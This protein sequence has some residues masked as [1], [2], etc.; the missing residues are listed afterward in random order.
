MS[1]NKINAEYVDMNSSYLY[2]KMI[3]KK[4]KQIKSLQNKINNLLLNKNSLISQ[5]DKPIQ[6]IP[7]LKTISPKNIYSKN[8]IFSSIYQDTISQNQLNLS[9]IKGDKYKN[10]FQYRLLSA[11]KEIEN[12]TIMNTSKDNIILNMQ[13]FIN[14]LNN[15][16]CNGKLNLNLNQIDIRLFIINLKFLEQKILKILQKIKAPNKIPDSIIESIRENSKKKPKIGN[17]KKGLYIIPLFSRINKLNTQS[18][19]N[20]NSKHSNNTNNSLKKPKISLN[21]YSKKELKEWKN[22]KSL[23][24]KHKKI[25]FRNLKEN[26]IKLQRS[27]L[28][29]KCDINPKAPFKKNINNTDNRYGKEN[30][31]TIN[32]E[33]SFSRILNEN[34]NGNAFLN[35]MITEK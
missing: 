29:K 19:L 23:T 2:K 7:S 17:N 5:I 27:F 21:D 18:S 31:K 13:T 30:W 35:K 28:S 14:N 32:S 34:N 6:R 26:S 9:V 4:D 24:G 33:M 15:A 11:Q 22:N 16:V 1:L 12:L 10:T 25:Q 8:K 20:D 3:E